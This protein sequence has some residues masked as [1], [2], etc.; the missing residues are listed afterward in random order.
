MSYIRSPNSGRLIRVPGGGIRGV[1]SAPASPMQ[2]PF[3]GRLGTGRTPGTDGPARSAEEFIPG[4]VYTDQDALELVA[5]ERAMSSSDEPGSWTRVVSGRNSISPVP[6]RGVRMTIKDDNMFAPLS[7]ME[8]ND[9]PSYVEET[10][11]RS[12]DSDRPIP[13]ADE[14]RAIRRVTIEEVPDEGD[15]APSVTNLRVPRPD[16]GKGV[17]RGSAPS[18]RGE[19]PSSLNTR[20][21]PHYLRNLGIGEQELDVD[22]QR[23]ALDSWKD[24]R[25]IVNDVPAR[26]VPAKP[27]SMDEYIQRAT[28]STRDYITD[29]AREIQALTDAK[30]EVEHRLQESEKSRLDTENRLKVIEAQ[31]AE[32]T[33]AMNNRV[34]IESASVGPNQGNQPEPEIEVNR[35]APKSWADDWPIEREPV[36]AFKAYHISRSG[37]S[38]APISRYPMRGSAK[39]GLRSTIM[40]SNLPATAAFVAQSSSLGRVLNRKLRDLDEAMKALQ[41]GD[42]SFK[43]TIKPQPPEKYSGKANLDAFQQFIEE[44]VEYLIDGQVPVE[45][46]VSK[47]RRYLSETAKEFYDNIVS[48]PEQWTIEVFLQELFNYCFPDGFLGE[49]RRKFNQ[50]R[51]MN[52]SVKSYLAKMESYR[53]DLGDEIG[54]RRFVQRV[55]SGLN[56]NISSRLY[57][58]GLHP[59]WSTYVDLVHAAIQAERAV[60]NSIHRDGTSA[61][62]KTGTVSS[63]AAN[64]SKA[65]HQSKQGQTKSSAPKD[66]PRN[67]QGSK[68]N[69]QRT[70]KASKQDKPKLLSSDEKKRHVE[71]NLC[72]VCHK[73]GHMSRNCPEQSQVKSNKDNK[74][75]GTKT[76]SASINYARIEELDRE[77]EEVAVM[78]ALHCGSV[79]YTTTSPDDA[80]IL[81]DGLDLEG[82]PPPFED[83]NIGVNQTPDWLKSYRATQNALNLDWI[84]ERGV[85]EGAIWNALVAQERI[86]SD[87]TYQCPQSAIE[88]KP[89]SWNQDGRSLGNPYKDRIQDIFFANIRMFPHTWQYLDNGGKMMVSSWISRLASGESAIVIRDP[90]LLVNFLCPWDYMLNEHFDL[91]NWYRVRL[92]E[93]LDLVSKHRENTV[94]TLPED[95]LEGSREIFKTDDSL[96]DG[97]DDKESDGDENESFYSCESESVIGQS[98]SQSDALKSLPSDLKGCCNLSLEDRSRIISGDQTKY[99]SAYLIG[100]EQ[101]EQVAW[102]N[103]LCTDDMLTYMD[104]AVPDTNSAV[105]VPSIEGYEDSWWVRER[106]GTSITSSVSPGVRIRNVKEESDTDEMPAL[107]PVSNSSE[108]SSD[109]DE[110]DQLQAFGARVRQQP[111]KDSFPSLQRN[112]A[113]TKVSGRKIPRPV[114]I[115]VH[116]N[117][118]ECRALLDSGSLGDFMSTTL[119]EQLKVKKIPL[120]TQ[121]TV[122][123]AAQ[124][125]KTKVNYYTMVKLDY[126]RVS[127]E[128][129]FDIM[130]I[131]SYDLILGTPFIWQHKI[132]LGLNPARI[133]IG[134]DSPEP[135]NNGEDVGVLASRATQ[136]KE[137]G[138]ESIREELRTYAMPLFKKAAETEL[139]P[140]RRI[141][142]RIP[143]K[144]SEKRYPFRPSKCP[145]GFREQ[146]NE[147]R[148]I[149]LRSGRW[150]YAQGVNAAP[151]M[152]LRKPNG[153]MRNTV[154]LRARNENTEKIASPL[155]DQEGIR[156]RV[157]G[158]RYFTAM[159]LEGAYEQVR[160]EPDD[161]PHTLMNT[162]DGTMV[163]LVLQQGDC[164]A[165]ATFMS[166][167]TDMFSAYLGV[168]LEIYLDDLIVHGN[169]L[170]DH[171]KHVKIVIDTL[172][173]HKFYLAESKMHFLADEIKL[174]GHIITHKGIYL[175][176]SKIDKISAWKVPVNRDLLRGFLGAVGYLADGCEGIRIPMDVLNKLTG[177][178][179]VFRWGPTE[180]RAFERV[181]EIVESH[182]NVHRI[183]MQYGADAPPVHMITDGCLTGIGG[184]IRQGADWKTAP[185]VAFYSAKLSA[186]QQNYAVHEIELLAGL[187]TMLR[188]RDILLGVRFKWYTDHKALIHFMNQKNLSGRQARWLEKMSEFDFEIVYVPGLENGLADSLSRIYSAESPGVVR[189]MEEYVQYDEDCLPTQNGMTVVAGLEARAI[190]RSQGRR[191]SD[192]PLMDKEKPEEVLKGAIVDA[193][194]LSQ[195]ETLVGEPLSQAETLVNEPVDKGKA[196]AVEPAETGRPETAKEF[197]KRIKKV[198]LLLPGER[199]EGGDTVNAATDTQSAK[200]V[201]AV[202]DPH[203]L[204][205][206]ASPPELS[207]TEEAPEAPGTSEIEAVV[208]PD[209]I[210]VLSEYDGAYDFPAC[211]K[212]KFEQDSF[213]KNILDN[214]TQFKNFLC[215][216][217]IVYLKDS[218]SRLLCIPDCMIGKRKAR[219]IVIA[220]AHSILA[221]LGPAKTTAYL[222]ATVWWKTLIADVRSYCETCQTCRRSKPDNQKPYGLLNPLPV[223]TNP[224]EA[225]GI[226][227]VGPLPDSNDRNGIYDEIT[228]IID[229]LSGRV[230]LVPSRQDYRARDVAEL[231]FSEVYRLHGLPKRIVSDRDVLFTSIFWQHLNKLLGIKLNMSSA[232]HPESDG[233][234]ERANRTV[235]QMIRSC[236]SIDQKDWV[237]KLPAVEFAINSAR[238]ESTG[239]APFF[240]D[241]GRMPRSMIWE[242]PASSEYPG[243][244]VFAQKMK[245][246]IMAAHDAILDSRVKQTRS[247]NRHR[248]PSPFAE[249]DMVYISTKNISFPKGRARK[250]IPKYIGP[251]LIEKDF[252]NNSYRVKLPGRLLQRGIHPVFHSSLMRVHVPN[253]DRLFPGRAENQVVDFGDESSE[254]AIDRV[255]SHKGKGRSAIFEVRWKAGDITWLPLDR[256]DGLEH[257]KLY[258]DAQGVGSVGEL[259]EGKGKPP[260]DDPQIYAGYLRLSENKGKRRHSPKARAY[261][262]RNRKARKPGSA[263]NDAAV[264]NLF[265]YLASLSSS[266]P[267]S[268]TTKS[269]T[270]VPTPSDHDASNVLDPHAP[271]GAQPMDVAEDVPGEA[272]TAEEEDED[273]DESSRPWSELPASP[274]DF[275]ELYAR[276]K[277]IIALVKG[278]GYSVSRRIFYVHRWPIPPYGSPYFSISFSQMKEY[279]DYDD[280]IRDH[281]IQIDYPVPQGYIEL[282]E[283]FGENVDPVQAAFSTMS[284]DSKAEDSTRYVITGPSPYHMLFDHP[285]LDAKPLKSPASPHT[286]SK[287][288]SGYTQGGK[289]LSGKGKST[290]FG[291]KKPYTD[292]RTTKKK[293]AYVPDEDVTNWAVLQ[294]ARARMYHEKKREEAM[295]R[296]RSRK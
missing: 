281:D 72:F 212:G 103:L 135:L 53:E 267:M 132:M 44:A 121:L 50:W 81:E 136:L 259:S 22:A 83:S 129:C 139:P 183:T 168:W 65:A 115:K 165:I 172:R 222:R 117:G 263:P 272:E 95:L 211:L 273:T 289:D 87:P 59:D 56:D 14:G 148:D 236:I 294:Q 241:T 144:D 237:S 6:L 291:N 90:L 3:E 153:G 26:Q 276:D 104:A 94:G 1:G 97:S 260:T 55:W 24:R 78:D 61:P 134:S 64:N 278:I 258:L 230:H 185:V 2:N 239:Y 100:N 147:K 12:S 216:N 244:R 105:T 231:I 4:T 51:Q 60:N 28:E 194:P 151:V 265:A 235:T 177:D 277:S 221:H 86:I 205:S 29:R 227:F 145:E 199:Q 110:D 85:W 93:F 166:V 184:C 288:N 218:G 11:V 34:P 209:L 75:P 261:K 214:P 49:I 200:S 111:P 41:Q 42:A 164:N 242:T 47:L 10:P 169:D 157:A 35:P 124:G 9:E 220:R 208:T 112:A 84:E 128:R 285:Q 213:F 54:D 198:T 201:D 17:D 19:G 109:C 162:P 182:R 114:V 174:L 122:Q 204:T 282:R 163:S 32:F 251:Y 287:G 31:M 130:N 229:L 8:Y 33:A 62:K 161:V 175:D 45:R 7:S 66:T 89:L 245:N 295:A 71:Q 269:A 101:A 99:E 113:R 69:K 108:C 88:Y 250:F 181:K 126:G 73:P 224:W 223:P 286:S 292:N 48:A 74:P 206:P 138:F 102:D 262:P 180:Q 228:V 58:Y 268:N 158:S 271:A 46:H 219:E 68:Q 171:V 226:D 80:F 243:V 190:T 156:R 154:D 39:E 150:Q 203:G 43:T 27:D 264:S 143:I 82:N 127:D 131:D 249:G 5:R 79:R 280:D 188:H 106:L 247:A 25:N 246:A 202:L 40:R 178:T 140:L 16:K 266:S 252:G 98:W 248:R 173:E 293:E 215:E 255:L 192:A 160:V 238:S 197:S 21:V 152:F 240:L 275:G 76:Y 270:K 120:E 52:N 187:E 38:N 18:D 141:N 116:I 274:E 13:R 37:Q 193:E 170:A 210:E 279:I 253:D 283:A 125:S 196:K 207:G 155:P 91:A 57:D 96:D 232:Y 30:T 146:W 296:R 118:H 290:E 63:S 15:T 67:D 217:G 186:A 137:E 284:Y 142:H 256:I 70:D 123:L 191:E 149:F 179:V 133:V 257:L 195:A 176:P 225:I 119:A 20:S 167:M 254:W 234:T 189:S 159:D 233:S 92:S 23:N 36:S 107:V 77:D